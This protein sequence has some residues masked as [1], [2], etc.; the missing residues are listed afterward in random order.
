MVNHTYFK[1]FPELESER[2]L[3]TKLTLEDASEIQSIRSNE[4]VMAFM[5]S[6]RHLDIED[7]RN[8]IS[9]NLNIYEEGLGIFWG[10]REKTSGDL[11]GDFAFHK[12]DN[13]NAR[14]EIGYTLKPEF[15]GRG[16]M[17]EAMNRILRFGFSDLRL[18]SIEANINPENSNSR[19]ILQKFGF[20]KEAYFRENYFYN[21]KFLDSEIYSLLE[22]DFN[23]IKR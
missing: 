21:G 15:W 2:L 13:K 20:Q 8:F 12:I 4:N 9:Q 1:T 23:K 5:D 11:I 18:H 7:S 10:I 14:G 6:T 19:R 17:Q 16:Y 3:L 22:S